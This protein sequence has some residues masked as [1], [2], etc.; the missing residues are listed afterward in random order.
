MRI[1]SHLFFPSSYIYVALSEILKVYTQSLYYF[2]G[3]HKH[4]CRATQCPTSF[5]LK[6]VMIMFMFACHHHHNH[7]FCWEFVL[8][9]NVTIIVIEQRTTWPGDEH[10]DRLWYPEQV[11]CLLC[12]LP[13][14]YWCHV[15]VRIHFHFHRRQKSMYANYLVV[16]SVCHFSFYTCV[17]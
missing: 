5:L 15:W 7:H 13:T 11:Y 12:P 1:S 14:S 9:L 3:H 6:T 4:S 17:S 16:V 2:E 8:V 10:R